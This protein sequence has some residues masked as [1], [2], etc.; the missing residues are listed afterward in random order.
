MNLPLKKVGKTSPGNYIFRSER[1]KTFWWDFNCAGILWC[2]GALPTLTPYIFNLARGARVS[3][4]YIQLQYTLYIAS[5]IVSL[6]LHR[7][8][9]CQV[10][11]AFSHPVRCSDAASSYLLGVESALCIR[12][13]APLPAQLQLVCRLTHPLS[14]V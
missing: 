1:D 8:I 4:V 10:G 12:H 9:A 2:R 6:M 14:A 3:L 7:P 5:R 13:L 11:F